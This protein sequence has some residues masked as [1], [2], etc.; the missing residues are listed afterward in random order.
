M[1][2]GAVILAGGKSRRMNYN[3]KSFLSIDGETFIE[4]IIDVLER[5]FDDIIIIT[6]DESAYL[7]YEKEVYKDIYVGKGPM[8]GIH[9]ALTN[10]NKDYIFV[11]AT[12]MPHISEEAIATMLEN[13][14]NHEIV[15]PM[16]GG[17]I[18]PLCGVY[19]KS[20]LSKIEKSLDEEKYK[21]IDFLL[22][23]NTYVV[24]C[25]EIKESLRNINTP[26]DY[27]KMEMD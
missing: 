14:D 22:S 20:I 17:K 2:I 8:A 24:N 16:S 12:D 6:N 3:N 7:N 21:L 23:C 15:V 11:V 27:K 25:D 19:S 18:H 10:A 5:R 9:S 1:N 4:K 13:L 26:E